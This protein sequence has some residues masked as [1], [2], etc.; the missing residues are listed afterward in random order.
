MY[1]ATVPSATAQPSKSNSDRI[2]GA[3]QS[4]FSRDMRRIRSR[5][6]RGMGGRPGFLAL[7]FHRQ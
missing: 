7:D 3:P 2:R 1:L 4:G 5:T 6:S